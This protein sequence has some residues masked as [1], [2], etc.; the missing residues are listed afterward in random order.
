MLIISELQICYIKGL[1][2]GN[3]I[4][5]CHGQWGQNQKAPRAGTAQDSDHIF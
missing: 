4:L 3:A 5:R 1:G 2:R